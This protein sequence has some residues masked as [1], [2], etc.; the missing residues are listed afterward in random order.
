MVTTRRAQL[1]TAGLTFGLA[2]AAAAPAVAAPN[3]TVNA[4]AF[5]ASVTVLERQVIG[6]V[7]TVTLGPDG[8]FK[9]ATLA[10]VPAS[11]VLTA[12]ALRA[13]TSGDPAA[14]TSTATGE[15]ADVQVAPAAVG[16]SVVSAQ[17]VSATCTAT[18]DGATGSA[19]LAAG[20]I[21][22]APIASATPGPNTIVTVP[23]VARVALNEQ[24]NN[25]DGS[26]TVNA[27]HV[28][29]LNGDGADVIV[30]SATC[31]P[32]AASPDIS[33]IPVA[34]LP[35]AGGLVALFVAGGAVYLRRRT[36][37]A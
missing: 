4:S 27:L 2:L 12:K 11:P 31:G 29:L 28:T 5:G 25:A 23:G 37:T 36:A 22:G 30:G 19:T 15:A 1:A 32:N 16:P 6:P 10:T 34:G 13:R 33:A 18:P 8:A 35:I 17:A 26:L 3:D 7:P 20:A 24:I 9:E 21:N 14:G